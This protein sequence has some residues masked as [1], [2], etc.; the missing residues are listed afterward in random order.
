MVAIAASCVAAVLGLRAATVEVRDNLDEF[1]NDLR[2]QG[3]WAS[4]AALAAAVSV[5]LQSVD[6]LLQ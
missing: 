1:I 4:W 3:R 5:V 2:R 6:R